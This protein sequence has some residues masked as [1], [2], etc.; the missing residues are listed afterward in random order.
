MLSY[1]SITVS[2]DFELQRVLWMS[3][4]SLDAHTLLIVHLRHDQLFACHL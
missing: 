4:I 1:Q 3:L 2:Y